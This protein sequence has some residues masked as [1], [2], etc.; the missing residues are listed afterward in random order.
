MY[1]VDQQFLPIYTRM[2]KEKRGGGGNSLMWRI[3]IPPRDS[4]HLRNG[5]Y[6]DVIIEKRREGKGRRCCLWDSL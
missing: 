2:W 3:Y 5:T 6:Y 4:R 1:K